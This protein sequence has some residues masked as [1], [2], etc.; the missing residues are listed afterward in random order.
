MDSLFLHAMKIVALCSVASVLVI[1]ACCKTMKRT[2]VQLAVAMLVNIVGLPFG[3]FLWAYREIT[4]VSEPTAGL[5]VL[6]GMG[7]LVI[8]TVVL[9]SLGTLITLVAHNP[10]KRFLEPRDDNWRS[11]F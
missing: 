1:A 10:I 11:D 9:M 4:S 6:L 8:M 2:N 7:L 3:Y 5:G